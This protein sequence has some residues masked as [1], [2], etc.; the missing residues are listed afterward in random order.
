MDMTTFEEAR[1]IVRRQVEPMWGPLSGTFYVAEWG[2]ENDQYFEVYVGAR[3]FLVDDDEDYL[4][5]DGVLHLVEK[6]TG[7]YVEASFIELFHRQDG[8]L[9]SFTPIGIG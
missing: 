3:E 8:V 1:E 4:Q 5:Y 6:A 2:A 7:K 9:D